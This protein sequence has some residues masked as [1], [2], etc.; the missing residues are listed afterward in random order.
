[1]DPR[2]QSSVGRSAA[3]WCASRVSSVYA[4]ATITTKPVIGMFADHANDPTR[5]LKEPSP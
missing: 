1:M 4:A 5:R 3:G 2:T